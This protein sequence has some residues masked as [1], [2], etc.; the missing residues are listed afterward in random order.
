MTSRF[1]PLLNLDTDALEAR[2]KGGSPAP[3]DLAGIWHG[4]ALGLAPPLESLFGRFAK[5]FEQTEWGFIGW[6]L[7]MKQ[8]ARYEPLR[9]CGRELSYGRFGVDRTPAYP[10]AHTYPGAVLLDYGVGSPL[11]PLSTVRD[12]IVEVD[13]DLLLGRMFLALPLRAHL[14]PT[15]SYFALSRAPR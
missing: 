13:R 14:L 2:M 8:N 6:N 9:L 3:T 5:V 10:Q 11:D 7:R 12:F 1:E 15:R 4:L